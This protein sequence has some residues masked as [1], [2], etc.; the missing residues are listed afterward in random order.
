VG[1]HRT[2]S[3][4]AEAYLHTKWHRDASSRLDTINPAGSA[5]AGSRR[6]CL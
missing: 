4:L 6:L 2:Q 3:P 5:A 1:P